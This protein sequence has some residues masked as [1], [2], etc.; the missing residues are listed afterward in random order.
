MLNSG[1]FIK[2]LLSWGILIK[3]NI[4]WKENCS[5]IL[6]ILLSYPFCPNKVGFFS[7]A[8][9]KSEGK[10]KEVANWLISNLHGYNWIQN[11]SSI[12]LYLETQALVQIP[13]RLMKNALHWFHWQWIE[14]IKRNEF[15]VRVVTVSVQTGKDI[16]ICRPKE[17]IFTTLIWIPNKQICWKLIQNEASACAQSHFSYWTTLLE[18]YN[19]SLGYPSQGKEKYLQRLGL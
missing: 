18:E 17:R 1:Q 10:K 8:K 12:W 16:N 15:G 13:L 3:Y 14:P 2:L 11:Q 19:V 7:A 9:H 6:V 4:T 5:F